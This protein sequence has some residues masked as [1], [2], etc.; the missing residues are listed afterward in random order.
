MQENLFLFTGWIAS[1]FTANDH[2]IHAVNYAG[3]LAI[4][5][6][7]VVLFAKLAT[8]NMQLVPRGSQNL[9]EAYLEGVVSMG[10][11]VLGSE[12]LSRKYLPLVATI[13]LIVFVSNII[14]IIP[15]FEAPTSSLNLTLTLALVVFIFYNFEGIRQNGIIKYF[16]HFMG[17]NKW[18]APIMF[19]VEVVSHL[20]RVVSL[21]F[22]LFGNIKGDDLFLLVVLALAPWVAPLPAFVLLTFMACLQTFIFMILTYV[23]LA[24]A[25]LISHDEH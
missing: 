14:G 23:Y 5:A 22:R 4:V 9:L 13:G 15:G 6:L 11:D 19:I 16:A 7:I 17:P 8:K 24:G 25:I 1:F 12:A 20:S 3:H 2:V 10:K 18:L 21:S